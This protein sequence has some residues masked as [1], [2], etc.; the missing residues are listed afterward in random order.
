[1]NPF[2]A[3]IWD[4]GLLADKEKSNH[5]RQRSFIGNAAESD[6][7]AASSEDEEGYR[8]AGKPPSGQ[9][10]LSFSKEGF[11]FKKRYVSTL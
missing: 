7:S 5:S 8:K 4:P 6:A 9:R 11:G 1:M 3:E 10:K 2:H